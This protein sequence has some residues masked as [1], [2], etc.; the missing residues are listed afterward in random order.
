M[1]APSLLPVVSLLVKVLTLPCVD[2]ECQPLHS[3]Q[4]IWRNAPIPARPGH[5]I[6]MF[7]SYMNFPRTM[8]NFR[9]LFLLESLNSGI[10]YLCNQ[11]SHQKTWKAKSLV[12][13]F[14][15]S[16]ANQRSLWRSACRMPSDV[17]PTFF[18]DQKLSLWCFCSFLKQNSGSK[19]NVFKKYKTFVQTLLFGPVSK[20]F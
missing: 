19:P 16:A 15:L 1:T 17:K 5:S 4:L 9:V 3:G 2:A 18:Q 20:I 8:Q 14:S 11:A 13:V 10:L 12:S 6:Q 7:A